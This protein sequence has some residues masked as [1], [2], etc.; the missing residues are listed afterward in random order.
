M[1]P[2]RKIRINI[3][4]LDHVQFDD[5]V[6]NKSLVSRLSATELEL[7]SEIYKMKA[8]LYKWIFASWLSQ[9][10]IIVTLVKLL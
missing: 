2:G 5:V 6:T 10:V 4:K 9:I 8:D 7:S 3:K 1:V